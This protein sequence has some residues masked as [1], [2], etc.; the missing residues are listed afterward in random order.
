[1]SKTAN[2]RTTPN[3]ATSFVDIVRGHATATAQTTPKPPT[4]DK[5]TRE[6]APSK[7][8]NSP[9]LDKLAGILDDIAARLDELEKE[10]GKL[11]DNARPAEPSQ[12]PRQKAPAKSIA[13][14]ASRRELTPEPRTWRAALAQYRKEHPEK[15]SDDSIVACARKWPRLY[16][17]TKKH[18]DGNAK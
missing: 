7:T 13:P 2:H 11:M 9:A 14:L 10:W 5:S 15:T 12:P 16:A 6:Q 18:L 3:L 1:M 4:A 8:K 17:T